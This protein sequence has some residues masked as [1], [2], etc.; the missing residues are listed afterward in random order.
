MS[1]H[2]S[3]LQSFL[4][5]IKSDI[6]TLTNAIMAAPKSSLS[7]TIS[8]TRSPAKLFDYPNLSHAP[9]HATLAKQK[10]ICVVKPL[11]IK[12]ADGKDGAVPA[13]LH[14]PHNYQYEQ[15]DTCKRT[16]AILLSGAGGGVVGPSGIYLSIADK[17]ASLNKGIPVMRLDYRFPA[18]NRLC[19]SDVKASMDYLQNEYSVS[20]FVLTGWSFGGAPVFTVGGDDTRVIGCATVASQTTETDG[21]KRLSPRPLLLLHGTGDKTLSP[22]CSERLFKMYGTRGDRELKLFDGDDHALT[23]NTL[24][25]EE[26]LCKFIMKCAGVE[27]GDGES[28]ILEENL[29]GDGDRA[30]LM[31]QGGDL[32]GEESIE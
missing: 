30:E 1:R 31:K 9:A 2:R 17:L 11:T 6:T 18:R 7:A 23:Q 24:T 16:A 10:A 13:F 22:S 15:S 8:S 27:I 3:I 32:K 20:Q 29:V 12:V 21:L 4:S 14:L 25:V 19:V 26:M 28:K 5:A